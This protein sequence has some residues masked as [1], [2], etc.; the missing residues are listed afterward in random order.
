MKCDTW[1]ARRQGRRWRGSE[2]HR[3][4]KNIGDDTTELFMFYLP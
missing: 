3:I 2:D 4:S 1:E